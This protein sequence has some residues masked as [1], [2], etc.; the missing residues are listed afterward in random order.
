MTNQPSSRRKAWRTRA[1][2]NRLIDRESLDGRLAI[3]KA[4][5]ALVAAIHVDLGGKEKLTAM[6]LELTEAFAAA[7]IVSKSI[8][9]QILTG[10]QIEP[11]LVGMLAQSINAMSKT[12][13][14]LGTNRRAPKRPSMEDWLAQKARDKGK[15]PEV[16]I[17][18]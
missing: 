8:N 6:E 7:S 10:A 1:G 4:Y 9:M 2:H 14:R 13:S 17:V 18:K 11:A 16:E 12:G 15:T 3:T 5:D